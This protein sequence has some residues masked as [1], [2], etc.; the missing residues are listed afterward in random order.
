[1]N[2]NPFRKSVSRKLLIFIFISL[3]LISFVNAA[4]V[5]CEKTTDNKFCQYVDES[6][7]A[8]DS[9]KAQTNCVFTSFCTPGCCFDLSDGRCYANS[10]QASCLS[11]GEDA[12]F[13]GDQNCDV[14][15]CNMGCCIIGQQAS[16]I[17]QTRCKKETANYPDLQMVFKEDVKDEASCLA[18][19]RSKEKG[20]CVQ[21]SESCIYTTRDNCPV[22]T[23]TNKGDAG[24]FK[25]TYCSDAK[26]VCDCSSG[27][28]SGKKGCLGE[29]DDVYYI[30]SCGN[31]EGVAEHCD[32][33]EG[34]TC[35]FDKETNNYKCLDLK[36]KTDYEIFDAAGKTLLAK[37]AEVQNGESWCEFDVTKSVWGDSLPLQFGKDLPGSRYYRGFCINNKMFV[38]PCE[39]FRAQ[40]CVQDQMTVQDQKY[41]VAGCIRNKF[42]DCYLQT[43]QTNC[44][45]TY[46]RDC[47]WTNTINEK[48]ELIYEGPNG[49]AIGVCRPLVP[50]G[51]KFWEGEGADSCAVGSQ[52]CVAKIY[53]SGLTKALGNSGFMESVNKITKA[54]SLSDAG[55]FGTIWQGITGFKEIGKVEC[56]QG[57]QCLQRDMLIKMNNACRALG[58][59]GADYNIIKDFN[60]DSF[61]RSLPNKAELEAH[62]PLTKTALCNGKKCSEN[63][64]D[65]LNAQ[66]LTNWNLP[67]TQKDDKKI[68]KVNW[69][70]VALT[71]LGTGIGNGL[72][73]MAFMGAGSGS[74]VGGIPGK[75]YG[76]QFARAVIPFGDIFK[77]FGVGKD[78]TTGSAGKGIQQTFNR[79]LSSMFKTPDWMKQNSMNLLGKP[80]EAAEQG[81]PYL[82]VGDKLY[83]MSGKEDIINKLGLK[84]DDLKVSVGNLDESGLYKVTSYKPEE[85]SK[86]AQEKGLVKPAGTTGLGKLVQG[87]NIVRWVFA[88]AS[89]ADDLLADTHDV[90]V[91]FACSPW[92]A[93]LKSTSCEDCNALNEREN[94]KCS[95]YTCKSFGQNCALLN[96]G[97]GNDTCVSQDP[98]DVKPPYITVWQ[99]GLGVYKGKVTET[100]NVGYKY[101]E[102]IPAYKMFSIALNTSEP[103]ICKGSLNKSLK[104]AEMEDFI[105]SGLFEYQHLQLM[106][107]PN[108]YSV[109]LNGT[110]TAPV[111]NANSTEVNSLAGSSIV[112]VPGGTFT[113]YV[114]CKDSLGNE[115]NA[116]YSIR[117][118]IKKGPD[119]TPPII[120]GSSIVSESYVAY[121]INETGVDIY[122]NEPSDCKWSVR[123]QDYEQ[124]ERETTCERAPNEIGLYTCSAKVAPI[125]DGIV[126]NFYFRCKDQPGVAEKDR[127]VNSQSFKL[128]LRGSNPLIINL[129]KPTNGTEIHESNFTLRV[130]T[131]KGATLDGKAYCFYGENKDINSMI[132]FFKT[133]ASVHEQVLSPMRRDQPYYYYVTCVDYG[134]NM[135]NATTN[136][137]VQKDIK[138]PSIMRVYPDDTFTPPHLVL[139]LTEPAECQYKLEKDFTFG[140][141]T[142]MA[143][144]KLRYEAVYEPGATYYIKCK[145]A[146]NNLLSYVFHA[147]VL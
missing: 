140:D 51:T 117:F 58:D 108:Q 139:I 92:Q 84:I 103:A 81:V 45:N 50:A 37:G 132:Q 34:T 4:Q 119:T 116:P 63:Y 60:L 11:R 3:F 57:C 67:N 80:I 133:N 62:E 128:T 39:D 7:C 46:L 65:I 61:T 141:G 70:S 5:C 8:A 118:S 143:A 123:D 64:G 89:L 122:V 32:Y 18:L 20:C 129:I 146:S 19:S 41:N 115:N 13:A 93:P 43:T 2:N 114:K 25:N 22:Q 49:A 17:T 99:D 106:A 28:K 14:A 10:P 91:T 69:G 83:D 127:N 98:R 136:V 30:D 96:A 137:I 85:F 52:E 47:F 73:D 109:I 124:M 78:V 77:L 142:A 75:E 72:I 36:C 54:M 82:E 16:F 42:E 135:A 121:G 40:W 1:M 131:S 71:T 35:G 76:Y 113:I 26:V 27:L 21:S 95:E 48:G 134:G 12:S 105:G 125:S 145:D 107:L 102:E 59:C 101:N 53:I 9:K 38:E 97:T 88:A 126:N 6:Q 56:V 94:R 68:E 66:D 104:F 86:L 33:T 55:T 23:A 144:E 138:A 29:S 112:L 74:I 100:P 110:A 147:S 120:E 44:E 15:Q 79:M 90:K 24:F 130:E 31:P 87:Y 111:A